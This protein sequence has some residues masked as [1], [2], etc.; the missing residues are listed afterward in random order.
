MLPSKREIDATV[1]ATPVT[2]LRV[3]LCGEVNSGKSTVLNALLRT[4]LLPDNIGCATRPVILATYRSQP[5]I[6]ITHADGTQSLVETDC[7]PALLRDATQLQ[8]WSDRPHFEGLEIIEVPLTKAEELTEEQIELIGS[9]DLMIWVTIASQAWRLTEKT[10]VEQLGDARPPRAILAVTRADKLRAARDLERLR[11]R[12]VRETV[13]YFQHCI[14]IHG[15]RREIEQATQSDA[16]WAQTGAA[17][18]AQILAGQMEAVRL[19]GR[20]LPA[21]EQAPQPQEP[22]AEVDV[23]DLATFRLAHERST[24]EPVASARVAEPAPEPEPPKSWQEMIVDFP[25]I[26]LAGVVATPGEENTVLHGDAAQ[27]KDFLALCAEMT[28]QLSGCFAPLGPAGMVNGVALATETFRLLTAS[29][30]E[31]GL[32]CLLLDARAVSQGIAQS[33]LAQLLREAEKAAR[34]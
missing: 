17:E 20:A 19:H 5:G 15:A 22:A 8:L 4:R 6:E 1:P 12:V 21:A 14:F 29:L 10:I 16:S 31:G 26:L 3:A 13:A 33:A 11:E 24:T 34:V 23:V 2:R 9:C 30:P 7:D 25:G 28:A 32:L 27:A 18:M